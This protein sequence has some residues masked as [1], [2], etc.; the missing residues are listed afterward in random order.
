MESIRVFRKNDF[1]AGLQEHLDKVS[2]VAV[3]MPRNEAYGTSEKLNAFSVVAIGL[4]EIGMVGI[5]DVLNDMFRPNLEGFEFFCDDK[6]FLVRVEEEIARIKKEQEQLKVQEEEDERQRNEALGV[7]AAVLGSALTTDEEKIDAALPLI[8]NA[9]AAH[10]DNRG[11]ET[12]GL[13]ILPEQ[14]DVPADLF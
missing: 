5:F 7:V 12:D 10:E 14:P 3:V 4:T 9:I 13:I 1:L 11:S 2:H 6:D 8:T